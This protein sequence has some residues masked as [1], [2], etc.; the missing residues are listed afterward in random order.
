MEIRITAFVKSVLA[1]QMVSDLESIQ[2]EEILESGSPLSSWQNALVLGARALNHGKYG[3]ALR[4]FE[5]SV[6]LNEGVPET[7][8]GLAFSLQKKL[9]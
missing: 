5:A 3:L 6:L 9:L 7:W 2:D 8:L 1:E 4:A